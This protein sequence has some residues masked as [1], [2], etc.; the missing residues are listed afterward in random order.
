MVRIIKTRY[1]WKREKPLQMAGFAR[2]T[3][4]AMKDNSNFQSPDI[5]LSDME[6]GASRVEN[7]WANRKNGPVAKDELKNSSLDLDTDLRAQ[8][9]YVSKIAKGDS[10]IIHSGGFEST[11]DV[12]KARAA[13]PEDPEAPVCT[14]LTGGGMKVNVKARSNIKNYLVVLVVDA[15]LNVTILNGVLTVPNGTTALVIN[16]TKHIVTFTGLPALKNVQVAAVYI[17]SAGASG[18]SPIA[19][20]STIV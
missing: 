12:T 4:T 20:A 7:A 16:S 19:T 18:I 3:A 11:E 6:K 17:N 14:A 5:A 8:A 13:M 10:T 9:D 15:P 2:G 1:S